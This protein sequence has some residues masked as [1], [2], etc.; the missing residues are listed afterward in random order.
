MNEHLDIPISRVVDQVA[1]QTDWALLE[2]EAARDAGVWKAVAMAVK[3]DQAL[4]GA[5]APVRARA[6]AAGLSGMGLVGLGLTADAGS[7]ANADTG[8]DTNVDPYSFSH[9]SA[10]GAGDGMEASRMEAGVALRG[11]RV[12]VW[13]GWAAAAALAMAFVAQRGPNAPG[14]NGPGVA[15]E[16]STVQTAGVGSSI[17]TANDALKMYMDKG[18]A[19]G[20]VLGEVPDRVLVRTT[21]DPSGNGYEVIY[22]RQIIERVRVDDLYRYSS[23]ERGVPT[24]VP[25]FIRGGPAM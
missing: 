2:A 5:L 15:G 17:M 19:D 3:Q 1:T 13:G 16:P 10:D 6:D 20:S 9:S 11:R 7:R 4:R 25:L 22:L 18:R 12:A 8:L 23:D 21:Q 14:L 24:P